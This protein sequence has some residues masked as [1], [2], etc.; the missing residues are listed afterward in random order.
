MRREKDIRSLFVLLR[1][2]PVSL[3]TVAVIY[4]DYLLCPSPLHPHHLCSVE[5]TFTPPHHSP[6][7][8][9]SV[10]GVLYVSS[11]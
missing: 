1:S 4:M 9:F 2:F 10:L 3:V 7:Y 5:L 8:L 11:T 6:F